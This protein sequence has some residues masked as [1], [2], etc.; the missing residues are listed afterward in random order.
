MDKDN[1]IGL[2]IALS[3]I[4]M[5]VGAFASGARVSYAQPESEFTI[6]VDKEAYQSGDTVIVTGKTG[7][8]AEEGEPVQIEIF[9][10]NNKFVKYAYGSVNR[11]GTYYSEYLINGEE[12][13]IGNGTYTVRASR[14]SLSAE[15]TYDVTIV[16]PEPQSQAGSNRTFEVDGVRYSVRYMAEGQARI[17]NMTLDKDKKSLIID[18]NP[19]HGPG[20][21][22]VELPRKLIDSREQKETGV[23]VDAGYNALV[24]GVSVNVTET[25][26]TEEARVIQIPYN[27]NATRIIITGTYVVPE[28]GF[29][30]LMTAVLL[31]IFAGISATS[32]LKRRMQIFY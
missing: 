19:E 17:H 28:F 11:M 9:G 3:I 5:L 4:A 26:N 1:Y 8:N 10:P 12:A 24:D 7:P 22:I 6:S 20:R 13:S 2:A 16:F 21:F 14:G 15:T 23:E 29:T 30:N 25:E 32:I 27:A 31:M 18:L